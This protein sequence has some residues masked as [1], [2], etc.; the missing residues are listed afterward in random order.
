MKVLCFE[1]REHALRTR[2]L[3][4]HGAVY[5]RRCC[6][7]P[8]SYQR[9]TLKVDLEE[10]ESVLCFTTAGLP[11]AAGGV[12]AASFKDTQ[13]GPCCLLLYSLGSTAR[14]RRGEAWE[15]MSANR[16]LTLTRHPF[17]FFDDCLTRLIARF[18][19]LFLLLLLFDLQAL[20][21]QG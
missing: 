4:Q 18:F 8:L 20:Q 5:L 7:S 15:L 12:L 9:S 13:R 17:F 11:R 19:V 2:R 14:C 6:R 16:E 21:D 3:G 10:G 1:P